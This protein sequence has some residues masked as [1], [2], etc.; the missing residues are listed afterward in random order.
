MIDVAKE[1]QIE[2]PKLAARVG[3][4]QLPA[5]YDQIQGRIFL[6][7]G[8]GGQITREEPPTAN[9]GLS[10]N[11]AAAAYWKARSV[12][13]CGAYEAFVQSFKGTFET[14]LAEEH[15]KKNCAP[16][17]LSSIYR[18]LSDVS[19]GTL[20]M[21][22]GPGTR[23][24]LVVAIPASASGISVAR[25]RAPDDGGTKPWCEVQWQR[26]SGWVSSCCIVKRQDGCIPPVANMAE[27][28]RIRFSP[29][30]LL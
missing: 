5:Y 27:Q 23:H 16:S 7:R 24:P 30:W 11:S 6:A 21:R 3:H 9:P 10:A 13:T 2:V 20:N 18:V 28:G 8:A 17:Q 29:R 26:F 25:C 4:R 19:Q 14:T 22:S 1:L 15:L 12:G